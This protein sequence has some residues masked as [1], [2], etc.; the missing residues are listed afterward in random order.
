MHRL[1][2]LHLKVSDGDIV[3]SE[4]Y[5]TYILTTSQDI[6]DKPIPSKASFTSS[7]LNGL[8]IASI[9]FILY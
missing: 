9:F 8:I 2:P 1:N 3:V 6:P 5:P 7:N 4:K